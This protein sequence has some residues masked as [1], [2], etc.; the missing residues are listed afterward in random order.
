MDFKN[1]QLQHMNKIEKL[2]ENGMKIYENPLGAV[3]INSN[4][5]ICLYDFIG[6][7]MDYHDYNILKE[8]NPYTDCEIIEVLF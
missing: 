3:F 2:T 4:P 5:E 8:W 6:I 7:Y 1:I